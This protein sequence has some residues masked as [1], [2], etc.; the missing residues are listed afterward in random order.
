MHLHLRSI[1]TFQLNFAF[2]SLDLMEGYDP[3]G[4]TA[5]AYE[6]RALIEVETLMVSEDASKI[7]AAAAMAVDTRELD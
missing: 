7:A 5:S 3:L 6:T 4:A 2:D 1:D